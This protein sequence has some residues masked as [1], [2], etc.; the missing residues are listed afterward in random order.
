MNTTNNYK[1]NKLNKQKNI[2]A[3]VYTLNGM[4]R[5]HDFL[6]SI[7]MTMNINLSLGNIIENKLS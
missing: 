2:I 6:F 3:N 5:M 4:R 1:T 7:T